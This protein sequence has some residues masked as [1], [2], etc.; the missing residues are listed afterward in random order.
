MSNFVQSLCAWQQAHGRHDLPWQCQD[1]YK[2]WLSEIMLQQTQVATVIDYY[3]RFLRRFPT[4]LSLAEAEQSEVMSYWA[5][6]GY[7]ARARNLHRCAQIVATDYEGVFPTS[8][9]EIVALPGIGRST[10]HA[11]MAFCYGS[12]TPIM[13]GNVKRLFTRY[14]GIKGVTSTA[15]VDRQLWSQAEAVLNEALQDKTKV[16]MARYTQALMDFGSLVCTRSS[17]KCDDCPIQSNCYAKKHG[18]QRELPT[19]KARKST[20][21]RRTV[22]LMLVCDGKILLKQRPQEGIWGGL[23]SLP[24]FSDKEQLL[25]HLQNQGLQI[26]SDKELIKMA[27]FEHIFSHFKLH[28][29]AFLYQLK[30]HQHLLDIS[31][32]YQYYPL[33]NWETLPL[34]KPVSTLLDTLS[35]ANLK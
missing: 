14:F 34:P 19:P 32:D 28:I 12:P 17:P 30:N 10:A 13:D 3:Q 6:L 24:E 5:G 16:N 25:H 22:M 23:L 27:A 33:N 7:Y 4:L 26:T 9:E 21:T 18:L 15:A 20:P 35:A 31:P 2:V 11:I 8:Y 1:P 29:Q